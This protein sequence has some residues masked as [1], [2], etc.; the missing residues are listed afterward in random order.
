MNKAYRIEKISQETYLSFL[1]VV[2]NTHWGNLML[3]DEYN[4]DMWG[5][6]VKEDAQ[7]IGGWVGML[8]G[9]KPVVRLIAKSVYFDSY[10]IFENS[11]Q[12]EKY[13][14]ALIDSMRD[15]ARKEG[16]V[17][18]KLT[19]WV[20]GTDLPYLQVEKNA[21]FLSHLP[22]KIDDMWDI[23]DKKHRNRFRKGEKNGVE[24]CAYRGEDAIAQLPIFQELR[25]Q[26]QQHAINRNAKASILLKSDK[27]FSDLIRRT[28]STLFIGWL[29][30]KPATV[31]LM[32]AS[33]NTAYYHM[34]GSDYELNRQVG[35]SAYVFWKV[36]EYYINRPDV[37]YV[38]MGGAPV[39]PEPE[40][41]AYG[42][43]MFKKSYGGEY[44]EFD[45]GVIPIS[46]W[47]YAVLKFAL[48]QRKLLRM[49]SKVF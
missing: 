45:A 33:G 34:G 23:V 7:V 16:V 8:R 15:W 11:E 6:V 13:Q 1:G 2:K 37:K 25:E 42:V 44:M 48:S 4:I 26:T 5:G 9:N 12:T 20:R 47:K 21:T 27:F 19:H 36:F 28:D 35:S 46:K 40:H 41:P 3:P 17:M 10:P 18:F 29:G 38:D 49:F 24:V 43:Y 32:I 31:A 30:D 14:L 22:E 39:N